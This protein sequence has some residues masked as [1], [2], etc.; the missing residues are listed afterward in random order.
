MGSECTDMQ[1]PKGVSTFT[2]AASDESVTLIKRIEQSSTKAPQQQK[3]Q[4]YRSFNIRTMM[5][6]ELKLS[7]SA[8]ETLP[9]SVSWM[10]EE[11]YL[12]A[13]SWTDDQE[14]TIL[15]LWGPGEL[16]IPHLIDIQPLQLISLSAVELEQCHPSQEEEHAFQQQLIRQL[17]ESLRISHIR[18]ADQ[19]LL[20]LML[21]IGER[22]GRVNSRGV[23]LS[24]AGMN[25]TH[26][27]L[28]LLSGL[29]RVTV[30]KALSRFRDGGQLFKLGDD[31]LL[32][33]TGRKP[34]N[35]QG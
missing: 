29:T 6:H 23:S 16:V 9:N 8:G 30:T 32:A 14:Y 7:L 18:S 31:E 5:E 11:G 10:I 1:A 12:I 34:V 19:R 13:A 20:Q 2:T 26:R 17:S 4:P 35:H 27:N 25:L 33:T 24:L 28:A 3:M 15:G 22:Y 21:W